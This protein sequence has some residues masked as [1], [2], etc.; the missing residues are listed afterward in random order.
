MNTIKYSEIKEI[1]EII[2]DWRKVAENIRD[3]EID[4]EV[5]NY[6]FIHSDEIDRIQKDELLSDTYILGCFSDWFI[7]DITGLDF[8]VVTKAQKNENYELLGELMAKEIDEVQ[9][10]YS[11]SDGYGHHFAHYDGCENEINNYYY[12]RVN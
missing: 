1:A 7:A 10:A 12:F 8:N 6:R 2:T 3:G 9:E 11:C 4:F 5:E